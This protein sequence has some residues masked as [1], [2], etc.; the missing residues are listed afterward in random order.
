MKNLIDEALKAHAEYEAAVIEAKTQQFAEDGI[1]INS[2]LMR[3]FDLDDNTPIYHELVCWV[4]IDDK[5]RGDQYHQLH[6]VTIDYLKFLCHTK[7]TMSSTTI[8]LAISCKQCGIY[9]PQPEINSLRYLGEL[10]A[11]PE[12]NPLCRDCGLV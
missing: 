6:L 9:I 4:D 5:Y 8:R 7:G 1:T 12:E 2:K 3:I 11:S 10:L